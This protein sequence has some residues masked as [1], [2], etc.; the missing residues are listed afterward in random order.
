MVLIKRYIR[1]GVGNIPTIIP[2]SRKKGRGFL[3]SA[4]GQKLGRVEIGAIIN[5]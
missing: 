2:E 1:I 5:R 4:G 3:A